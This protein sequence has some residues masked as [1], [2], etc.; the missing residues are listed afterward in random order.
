MHLESSRTS[1]KTKLVRFL[2]KKSDKNKKR[3]SLFMLISLLMMIL[4]FMGGMDPLRLIKET[5][6]GKYNLQLSF[7]LSKS[8]ALKTN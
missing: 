5:R 6:Y 3:I 7:A 1:M 2:E 4:L 8:T